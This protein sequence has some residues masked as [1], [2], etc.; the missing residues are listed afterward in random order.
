[1]KI[2][3]IGNYGATNI[4]DESI[5]NT[6]I[7]SL[8]GHEVTVFSA[9]PA[10]TSADFGVKSAHIFPLGI[11][12]TLKFGL[13][14]SIK[15]LK[16][17]DIVIFGGGG[18]FQD[19]YLYAC[20]LWAWQIYWVKRLKKPLFIYGAGVG[21][22]NTRMGKSIAR[23]AFKKA[24]VITVRDGYSGRLLEKMGIT[25]NVYTTAD[26]V[27][28]LRPN[29]AEKERTK[30]LFIISLRP[31]LDCDKT[32]IDSFSDF[33]ES[34]KREKNAEFIFVCMQQ[35]REHDHAVIGPLVKKF[36]GEIYI[37]KHFSDLIKVMQTAEFAIGM[38]YHFLI[39]AVITKTPVIPISYSPKVDELFKGTPLASYLIP[40]DELSGESL[41]NGLKKLSVDYNNVIVY[42]S[43]RLNQLRSAARKNTG[44][45]EDFIKR[46]DQ[47][48]IE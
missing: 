20:F 26:P 11:R 12:S 36:G 44:L 19:D 24:D 9:D 33:L 2:G 7:K 5:L 3:I 42:E 15:A 1:M 16:D 25:E 29:D 17:V 8:H 48:N 37:P 39:A 38:R 28:V 21:P 27:F 35:I 47:T 30:N 13:K 40:V 22:L 10:K 18:L 4:G 23:W 43:V 32:V 45:L 41:K 34:L 31:W 46:F 14:E 6:V